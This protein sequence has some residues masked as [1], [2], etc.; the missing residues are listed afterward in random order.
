[1]KRTYGPTVTSPPLNII[2][3]FTPS[4]RIPMEVGARLGPHSI[5]AK[6]LPKESETVVR[7]RIT[8]TL[9]SPIP[10]MWTGSLES[11]GSVMILYSGAVPGASSSN[12]SLERILCVE[13]R[14]SMT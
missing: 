3:M 5:V 1:M 11:R 10:D 13:N 8:Q 9:F 14:R 2:S 6:L 12:R 7:L 4:F